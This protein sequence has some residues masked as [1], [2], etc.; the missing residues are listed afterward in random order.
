MQMQQ[1]PS[2]LNELKFF[3]RVEN[4]VGEGEHAGYHHFLLFK[5]FSKNFSSGATE[6]LPMFMCSAVLSDIVR[7]LTLNNMTKFST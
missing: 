5:L 7:E 4:I 1:V 6:L 3:D 2:C